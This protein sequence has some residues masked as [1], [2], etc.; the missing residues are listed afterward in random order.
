MVALSGWCDHRSYCSGRTGH[1]LIISAMKRMADSNAQVNQ[2]GKETT[3]ARQL[4]S[5]YTQITR[6]GAISKIQITHTFESS[7]LPNTRRSPLSQSSAS[8]FFELFAHLLH[9]EV[10]SIRVEV[11]VLQ[12]GLP[13]CGFIPRFQG[14]ALE[15]LLPHHG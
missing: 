5:K 13:M 1:S 6:N 12:P 4:T 3:K 7:T 15:H 14:E 10:D 8:R 2:G 9:Y 11:A